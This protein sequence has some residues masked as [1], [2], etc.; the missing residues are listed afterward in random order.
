[1]SFKLVHCADLHIGAPFSGLSESYSSIRREEIK[2]SLKYIAD[3]SIKNNADAILICGDLFDSPFPAQSDVNYVKN[4]FKE[5]SNINIYITCGN[6][7]YLA[8]S[9]VFTESFS[10]LKNVYIFPSYDSCFEIKDK[11][12]VLWGKSYSS[13]S[14]NPSFENITIDN[15]KINIVCLHGVLTQGDNNPITKECLSKINADYAAFGHIHDGSEFTIGETK[16]AY[17]GAPEGHGFND[18]GNTGFIFAQIEKNNI[19]LERIESSKRKYIYID[20]DISDLNSNDEIINLIKEKINSDDLFKVTLKGTAKSDFELSVSYIEDSLKEYCFFIKIYNET[21]PALDF[22]LIEN[23]ESL[24][25]YFIRNLKEI[26]SEEEFMLAARIGLNAL[27][28]R[29]TDL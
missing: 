11:N 21:S 20:T 16:C 29:K 23:E 4:I 25:G 6:H 15:E 7:D 17:S 24:R 18:C 9:S 12:V 8:P 1:M 26:A 19:K 3:F 27:L 5:I 13:P 10:D 28:G 14:V 22:S 2:N